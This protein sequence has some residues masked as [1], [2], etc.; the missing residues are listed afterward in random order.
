MRIHCIQHAFFEKPGY[1]AAWA[2]KHGHDFSVSH[3]YEHRLPSTDDFDWLVLLGGPMSIHDERCYAW[4]TAEKR[5]I[6]NAISRGRRILG[7]CLGA[8]LL[9]DVLGGR[10][11]PCAHKEVGW[12]PVRLTAESLDCNVF[13]TSYLSRVPPAIDA[14]HWHGEGFSLPPGARRIAETPACPNQAFE[15]SDGRAQVWG[16]QFHLEMLQENIADLIANC[17]EDCAIANR[18]VQTASEIE[19]HAARIGLAHTVLCD[20]LN[21]M[22]RVA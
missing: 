12:W 14:F 8:Q 2:G 9:A 7:V 5:L 19:H 13:R 15:W 22:S 20:W 18:Y 16:L 21:S 17:G 10:V 6:E 4:M 1:L 3:A 11:F